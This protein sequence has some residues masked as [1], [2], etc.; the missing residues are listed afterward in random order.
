LLAA[1]LASPKKRRGLARKIP[2]ILLEVAA[3]HS[4]VCQAGD[5]EFRGKDINGLIGAS[6]KGTEY[7]GAFKIES[8]RRK[9]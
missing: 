9:L 7:E 1:L 5:G 3:T 2:M 6:I 8:V 4:Q